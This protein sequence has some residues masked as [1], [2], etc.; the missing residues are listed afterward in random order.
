MSFG[1]SSDFGL[2][3]NGVRISINF[4]DGIIEQSLLS[5]LGSVDLQLIFKLLLKRDETTK[6]KALCDLQS[7]LDD[8]ES[9][10]LFEDEC[11]ALCWSQ[12]Y[13]KLITSESRSIRITAHTITTRLI[14]LLGKKSARFLK[15]FVPFLLAGTYDFD[16]SV[17]KACYKSIL[18]CFGED[19]A[20]VGA[21]WKLFRVQILK[22][23]TEVIVVENPGLLS[24]ERYVSKQDSEFRYI[25]IATCAVC[26]L[27]RLIK[28]NPE[29][30]SS[31][32]N[33][34]QE[35]LA[36]EELWNLLSFKN[37]HNLKIC[38][39]LL[40]LIGVLWDEGFLESTKDILKLVSKRLLK[41]VGHLSKKN[42]LNI[43]PLFPQ[44][45]SQLLRLTEYRDGKFLSW[46]KTARDKIKAFLSLGPGNSDSTYY[47]L[48]LCLYEK[49]NHA[50]LFD[51]NMDWLKYWR[52]DLVYEKQR[53]GVP[54]KTQ[55]MLIEFWN[56]YLKF[57]SQAPNDFRDEAA[58][59]ATNDI[60]ATL[61][62]KPFSL[63]DGTIEL[64]AD[65]LSFEHLEKEIQEL[66]PAGVNEKH[67]DARYIHNLFSASFQ[68]KDN[69]PFLEKMSK[70]MV[71]SLRE[72]HFQELHCGYDFFNR[73]IKSKDSQL[74][75]EAITFLE[76][77][78]KYVTT[79]LFNAP[80]QIFINFS[81]HVP[82]RGDDNAYILRVF[83]DLVE[84]LI[85]LDVSQN[86][87]LKIF[88]QI[89]D[90]YIE[91]LAKS[92]E[93][94][95]A[96]RADIV[97]NFDFSN[98]DLF[99][100][101]LMN[102]KSLLQLYEQALDQSKLEAFC[103]GCN[104]FQPKLYEHLL[105]NS[106]LLVHIL[107]EDYGT[108]TSELRLRVLQLA[109][110]QDEIAFK[111]G[112]AA[113]GHIEKSPDYLSSDVLNYLE[114]LLQSNGKL[115]DI[116]L[117]N[118]IYRKLEEAVPF[119]SYEMALS[120]T[121][122]LNVHLLNTSNSN[123]ALSSVQPL[124]RFGRF[125]DALMVKLPQYLD[126]KVVLFLTMISELASDF[127]YFGKLP[128]N[129]YKSFECV[130]FKDRQYDIDASTIFQS[131]IDPKSSSLKL[132]Q[133]LTTTEDMSA[134][135]VLFNC[136][137]LKKI[138]ANA[139]DCSSPSV[140]ENSG[141]EGFLLKT[142]RNKAVS[143][144]ELMIAATVLSSITRYNTC[145][146]LSKTRNYLA[147]ELIGT[148]DSDLIEKTPKIM[149]LL[150]NMLQLETDS[151]VSDSFHAI[152]PQRLKMILNDIERW[153]GSDLWY[154]DSSSLLRLALLVF[155]RSLL[156]HPSSSVLATTIMG[157]CGR[158]V[159]DCSDVIS[160]GEASY[161]TELKMCT[162]NLYA[163]MTN[164]LATESL[165]LTIDSL[166]NGEALLHSV[167][168]TFLI[169]PDRQLANYQTFVFYR[170]LT[171][172]LSS[173][174]PKAFTPYFGKLVEN[175]TTSLD[176][177]I[178]QVRLI[179]SILRT[180][181]LV[182]QQE[183]LIEFEL[184]NHNKDLEEAELQ[185]FQ[186]PTSLLDSLENNA[187]LEY[188]EYENEDRFLKYLWSC[189]LVV[190][191][192]NDI[193]YNLRQLY[194]TQLKDRD[195]INKLFDFIADQL[196][197]NDNTWVPADDDS[198]LNY[199]INGLGL[200]STRETVLHESKKLL[201]HLLYLLFKNMG[202]ITSSW[203]LNLKDR[204]LQLKIEKFVTSHISP[205]LIRQEL[206]DVG[207]RVKKLTD[208]DASLTIKVN[209][210]S[211]EI[212]AGYLVDEQKLEISLKLPSNYPLNNI[213]VHGVSR[214]GINE[215]KWKTWI[216]SAQRVIIGMNGSV[217]D[218]LELFTKNVNLHFSGFEECAICYSILHAVDR[219]LPTKVCPTCN[220]RFHG[221]CLYKWF[222]SSGNNTCPLCRSEIPFRR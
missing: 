192:F 173:S 123:I 165:G 120:S 172:A 153:F 23:V 71:T 74:Q 187:P 177:N 216:L 60:F 158:L 82:L 143:D 109:E 105:L 92:S 99:K 50:L 66:L 185:R 202:S 155:F 132:L 110:E 154:E 72:Y 136:R 122:G 87:K 34:Y 211:N 139:I 42:V 79:E 46:D 160:I 205:I 114:T 35:L 170:Q 106:D 29:E 15:D 18:Q 68:K 103:L 16:A 83:G 140:I 175:F 77:L 145:E 162:I 167:I 206:E 61:D 25:R 215:Q 76:V 178:D 195:L 37:V 148:R 203:W 5:A 64:F 78:S 73:I 221:A 107:F 169:A 133:L 32:E 119:V 135:S 193:S 26:V 144:G 137:I 179:I 204:A 3:N 201:L 171:K 39:A 1:L 210:I 88:D 24:D 81:H 9:K 2:G 45:L 214:V 116:L 49:S 10:Y 199:N 152:A 183:L 47:G 207:R 19:P 124:I 95:Q 13:A 128:S 17:G 94:L 194:I 147:S 198:V 69:N 188:L 52:N 57:I 22:F 191:Y 86:T 111:V 129:E 166:K 14:K 43:S 115:I 176:L 149:I 164:K 58:M 84:R 168:E 36:S 163:Q 101:K 91:E 213:E 151:D 125:L 6:D 197:L 44:I 56:N 40:V 65:T 33:T 180:A 31:K 218:S 70:L 41:A 184:N 219:K 156:E 108:V 80:S 27:I 141:I 21:L 142:V 112:R 53:R 200:S 150:N 161:L 102:E 212:K 20:K 121:L 8:P 85:K 138:L 30:I 63:F 131:L 208:Q 28:E 48:L 217:M 62:E 51:Y 190:S 104:A 126:E 186:L 134:V 67:K 38:E 98:D 189:Y 90:S 146:S 157:H 174:P 97:R 7:L 54:A 89:E 127:E 113:L 59:L 55:A 159:V 209:N 182:K 222:R 12:I 117:P 96:F 75:K 4:F 118:N 220:N 181:I 130:L 100:S 11:F 93:S 196:D